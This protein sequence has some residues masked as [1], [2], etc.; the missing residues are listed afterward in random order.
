MIEKVKFKSSDGH[1]Q[2]LNSSHATLSCNC[3][4]FGAHNIG[5]MTNPLCSLTLCA[6]CHDRCEIIAIREEK[7]L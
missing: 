2:I 4:T 3:V 5:K 7:D 1:G 6:F